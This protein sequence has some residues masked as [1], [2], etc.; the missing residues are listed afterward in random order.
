MLAAWSG[1]LG[2]VMDDERDNSEM[3]YREIAPFLIRKGVPVSASF[4]TW[5]EQNWRMASRSAGADHAK[6]RELLTDPEF[7]SLV[8][9][10]LGYKYHLDEELDAAIDAANEILREIEISLSALQ[11]HE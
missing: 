6:V 2:E 8:E 7:Q 5:G 3:V 11:E 1:V 10:R 9:L 4:R